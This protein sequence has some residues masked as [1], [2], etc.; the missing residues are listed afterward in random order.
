MQFGI[1]YSAKRYLKYFHALKNTTS[2]EAY[3]FWRV[4]YQFRF[5]E[6]SKYRKL[7]MEIEKLQAEP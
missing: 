4:V 3:A 1:P 5:K 6:Q 2:L 7:I